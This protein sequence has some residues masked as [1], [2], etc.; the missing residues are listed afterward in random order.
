[1]YKVLGS[2]LDNNQRCLPAQTQPF[3]LTQ[4][5]CPPTW[6]PLYESA[7]AA[8]TKYHGWGGFNNRNWFSLSA[9]R[10]KPEIKVCVWF[11]LRPLSSWLIDAVFSRWPPMAVPAHGPILVP[12]VVYKDTSHTGLGLP[13][14]T[15]F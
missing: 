6:D 3:L 5:S 9:R 15:S 13:A 14:K 7:Q 2:F 10:W 11:P 4:L 12:S 1:M 8:I